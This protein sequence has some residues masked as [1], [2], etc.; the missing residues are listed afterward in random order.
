MGDQTATPSDPSCEGVGDNTIPDVACQGACDDFPPVPDL[1]CFAIET[2]SEMIYLPE[3]NASRQTSTF[4]SASI[5]DANSS[6]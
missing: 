2:F 3:T 6:G 4:A 5:F 1:S